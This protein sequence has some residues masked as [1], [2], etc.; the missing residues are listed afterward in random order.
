MASTERLRVYQ[1]GLHLQ[2]VIA[3]IWDFDKTLTPQ[4]MQ[5]PLFDVYG[6]DEKQFWSEVNA[7]PGYYARAG[8]TVQPDTCYLGHLLTYVR[9]GK[10][11]GLTNAKLRELGA[12]IRLFPGITE[13]FER[14]RAVL[15]APL[16]H[17]GD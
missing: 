5:S 8:V 4:Y 2:N 12:Q 15:D 9:E 6:V 17:E 7:L 10:M 16:Y 3:V 1:K 13:L 11:A 14:L